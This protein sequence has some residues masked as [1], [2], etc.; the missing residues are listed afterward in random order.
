MSN[1]PPSIYDASANQFNR[2]VV[3][4]TFIVQDK[5]PS[6]D[7]SGLPV[8]TKTD[9][10]NSIFYGNVTVK[11]NTIFEKNITLPSVYSSLPSQTELG[12]MYYQ[13][14]TT[15]ATSALRNTYST[16]GT[17]SLPAGCYFVIYSFEII[18]NAVTPPRATITFNN[19]QGGFHTA[20][21]TTNPETRIVQYG[22]NQNVIDGASIT[23]NGSAFYQ[24]NNS[25]NRT[26]YM[27][28]LIFGSVNFNIVTNFR[29]IK[30]G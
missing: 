28:L 27:N 25:T 7:A 10:G 21:G 4:G 9:T 24:H 22:Y 15:L 20:T 19:I 16:Y 3:N 23:V 5:Y 29:A 26:V 18:N 13:T 30:I 14:L 17:L 6:Y 12:G 11:G 1:I 8:G 2:S